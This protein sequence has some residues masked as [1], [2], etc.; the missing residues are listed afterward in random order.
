MKRWEQ[1]LAHMIGR[2]VDQFGCAPTAVLAWND[3]F[4]RIRSDSLN[5]VR[6]K[7]S[8][9]ITWRG[10]EILRVDAPGDRIILDGGLLCRDYEEG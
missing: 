8:P 6:R 9:K 5:V 3:A 10:Y 1:E 2:F 7:G 4:N